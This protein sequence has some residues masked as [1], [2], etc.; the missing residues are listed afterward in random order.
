MKKSIYETEKRGK[1]TQKVKLSLEAECRTYEGTN[2][3]EAAENYE[4][5]MILDKGETFGLFNKLRFERDLK[6]ITDFRAKK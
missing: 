5:T 1:D 3:K 6:Q 4:N 2:Q